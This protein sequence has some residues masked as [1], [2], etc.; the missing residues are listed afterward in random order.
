MSAVAASRCAAAILVYHSIADV[1]RD[2]FGI[3]VAPSDFEGQLEVLARRFNVLTL[4][5]LNHG[6]DEG[7]LPE[8]AVVVTFDDGYANNLHV[9]QPALV[10][11]GVPA[12]LFVAS[13]YIGASREFWWDEVE[14][15]ICVERTVDA[16]PVLELAVAGERLRCPMD[17][18]ADAVRRIALWLQTLPLGSVDQG[19]EQLRRWAGVNDWPEPRATHRP[20]TVAELRALAGSPQFEIGAHT[21]THLRLGAQVPDV[22]RAE[23]EGSRADLESWLGSAPPTFAYPFGNPDHDYSADTVATVRA[24]GFQAAV[25]GHPG[26]ARS[27]SPRHQLPRW[28]V[29]IPEPREFERWL[30][31]RFDSLPRRVISKA[32][33]RVRGRR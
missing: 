18:G 21:R 19:L 33:A 31:S 1:E 20:L 6:L 13:G 15:L 11:H 7:E 5:Q 26:L 9:A 17:D 8:R 3:T 16:E 29:T 30:A 14:R 22:Q 10:A 2:P 28:F 25:S 24:A 12:T 27:F 32:M 4:G 23:I